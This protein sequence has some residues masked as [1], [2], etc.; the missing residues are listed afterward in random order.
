MLTFVF[1]G[2]NKPHVALCLAMW[3]NIVRPQTTSSYFLDGIQLSLISTIFFLVIFVFNFSKCRIPR[4][5]TYHFLMIGFMIWVTAAHYQAQFPDLSAIKYDY[6]IKTL[7][8]A[9]LIS[10]VLTTR[11]QI[12]FFICVIVAAFSFFILRAGFKGLLGGG[13]YGI[14][15]IGINNFLYA[16]GSTLSTLAVC[17]LPLFLL[18]R[19][20]T[21][22]AKE[23]ILVKHYFTLLILCTLGVLMA[24]QARTGLVALFV[25]GI[26]YFFE[27]KEKLKYVVIG[28]ILGV[29]LI[30]NVSDSWLERMQTIK[31][32]TTSETSALGRIV[33]WRWTIDYVE[34]KPLFG[35]GF[36]A[37]MANE[38]VLG[39]Y[40]SAGETVI[41]NK[42]AKAFHNILFEVL[43]ET[44]YMG[45]FIFLLLILHT[46]LMLRVK[47]PNSEEWLFTDGK[48]AIRAS[49]IIYC[50]GGM[51]VGIAFYPWMYYMIACTVAVTEYEKVVGKNKKKQA[52]REA[53]LPQTKVLQHK[54]QL[55][56]ST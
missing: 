48:K 1:Y 18:I 21:A 52:L 49:F 15:L 14:E 53:A 2:L 46:L 34:D 31:K 36:Y 39:E 40:Q 35:G 32:A 41:N 7:F 13:G 47:S 6:T 33:V 4:N 25:F 12:E 10:F 54:T 9:Y 23:N 55:Q 3:V 45:L 22:F 50:A 44:G 29:G 28:S 38:G 42:R 5:F 17:L 30:Y 37:Y 16:E 27:A 56:Q 8:F 11:K 43:G 24:T 19:N 51:F 20:Y 26:I